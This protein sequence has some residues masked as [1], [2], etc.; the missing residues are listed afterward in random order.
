M[1]EFDRWGEIGATTRMNH[2]IFKGREIGFRVRPL[3]GTACALL[4]LAAL[5]SSCGDS[6]VRASFRDVSD[7]TVAENVIDADFGS[8]RDV[9][10]YMTRDGRLY[11]LIQVYRPQ[12]A[13][14]DTVQPRLWTCSEVARL[15]RSPSAR[16]MLPNPRAVDGGIQ[17]SVCSE[18]GGRHPPSR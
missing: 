3:A 2:V 16:A 6:S 11:L 1:G 10:D 14:A 8:V 15:K 13:R 9:P 17:W 4:F 7:R 18:V 5:C 12:R